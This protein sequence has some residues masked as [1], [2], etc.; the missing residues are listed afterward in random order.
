MKYS[1]HAKVLL[2]D[3][4]ALPTE[5]CQEKHLLLCFVVTPSHTQNTI[6]GSTVNSMCS[7]DEYEIHVVHTC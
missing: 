5:A 6:A 7:V 4:T 3:F 2:Y 1:T